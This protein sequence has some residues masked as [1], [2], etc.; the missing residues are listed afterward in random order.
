MSVR[1]EARD[2]Y[3]GAPICH[4]PALMKPVMTENIHLAQ[5]RWIWHIDP[6]RWIP[7]ETLTLIYCTRLRCY[8]NRYWMVPQVYAVTGSAKLVIVP[9]DAS[10]SRI[11]PFSHVQLAS[12][13]FLGIGHA[14]GSISVRTGKLV[15]HRNSAHIKLPIYRLG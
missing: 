15:S 9:S 4:A 1:T 10:R 6:Q 11:T 7:L 3:D 8:R 2:N 14:S 13:Q 12:R 5:K